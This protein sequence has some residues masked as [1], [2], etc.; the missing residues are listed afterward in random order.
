M[1]LH[2][3]EVSYVSSSSSLSAFRAA[4]IRAVWSSKMPLDSTPAVLDLL[5]GPVGVDPSFHTVWAGFRTVRRYLRTV[6]RR[7]PGFFRMLD[8]ISWVA[9][10]HGPVHLLLTTAYEVGFAWDG[11]EKG[12]VRTCLPRLGMM[13]GP[14]SISIPPFWMLGLIGFSPNYLRGKVFG[15]LNLQI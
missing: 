2:A 13:S 9:Q 3:V 8:L 4:I 6:L 10:G 12:W 7:S 14:F 5:D 15:E 1:Y 11:D